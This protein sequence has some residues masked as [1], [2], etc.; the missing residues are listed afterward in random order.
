MVK[1]TKRDI[2]IKK[3]LEEVIVADTKTLSILFFNNSLRAT[4]KRLKMLCDD[5]FLKCY[6][7]NMLEQNI[8]YVKKRSINWKHKIIFSQLLANLKL[9]NIEVLKYRTPYQIEN[10]IADGLI[11]VKFDDEVK[12]YF[13]EG[14]RK[15]KFDLDKYIKLYYSR[16]WKEIFPIFPSILLITDNNYKTVQVL[17]IIRCSWSLEDLNL[18]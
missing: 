12:I 9:Q 13:V 16:K 15:K 4:Q 7:E 3:F 11:V 8:Y 18:K 1:I 5:K 14:E 2:E 17:N 10:V 6:R